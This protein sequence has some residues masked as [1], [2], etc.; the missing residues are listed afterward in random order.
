ISLREIEEKL[1]KYGL[2][3]QDGAS[4]EKSEATSA[5]AKED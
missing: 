2:E 1:K 3:L 5:E 4:E